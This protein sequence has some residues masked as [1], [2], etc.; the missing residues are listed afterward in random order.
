ME[1]WLGRWVGQRKKGSKA[2]GAQSSMRR[3]L[4]R[5]PLHWRVLIGV[6]ALAVSL[7]SAAV[8]SLLLYY[9][10]AFP[11]PLELRSRD[12]A[13]VIQIL[14]RDGSVLAE[15]GAAHAYL[16]IDLMPR[17]V[18][19]A[20]LATEDRRFFEHWGVDPY[21]LS[22]AFFANM[23][24]GHFAQGGSTLT[25]QLAK[26]LFLSPERSLGR[27]VEELVL[28]F[29]LEL[30]L[31]KREI[32][33]LYL[34]RVYFGGGAYGI[35]AAAQ[36][37]FDKSARQLTIG[38]AAVVAGLLKAP[39]RYAPSA[40]PRLAEAR[41]RV[42]LAKMHEARFITS[43]EYGDAKRSKIKF[44]PG[45]RDNGRSAVDYAIDYALEHLPAVIGPGQAE[46]I[47]DTTIDIR[48]Q[49]TASDAVKQ[50][51]SGGGSELGAG[52]AALVVLDTAGGIRAMVGG[53]S[54]V[55][56]QFNR[57]VK[58]RRQ[59]GSAMKP[60]VYLA[61]LENGFTPESIAYDLPVT[62]E[63][64]SPRNDNGKYQG[65]VSLRQALAQSINTV[66][67]RLIADTGPGRVADLA[68]RMGIE[69]AL[70]SDPSLALGTSEVSLLELTGAYGTFANGGRAV[71]PYMI[72]RIRSRS[73]RVLYARG[74]EPFT[75]LASPAAVGALNDMLAETVRSGTGRRAALDGRPV[76]GK[77]GTSQEFRDAWFVGYTAQLVAGVWVGNDAGEPM[78]KVTGG[79]L[80]AAIW[81]RVMTAAHVN[82]PVVALPGVG[83]AEAARFA[84][85]VSQRSVETGSAA[86]T[87]EPRAELLPWTAGALGAE[88]ASGPVRRPSHSNA[89]AREPAPGA[90]PRSKPRTLGSKVSDVPP[91]RPALGRPAYPST[92]ISSDFISRALAEIEPVPVESAMPRASSPPG[93]MTLGRGL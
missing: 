18:V 53:R 55:D 47:V 33:E 4:Q 87:S 35:E 51:L 24:A 17:A 66:A 8:A 50:E 31:S 22:R 34:N 76:A 49:A 23:R 40:N 9:T 57:A 1:L 2:R 74:P 70:R 82:E 20:V 15:R 45:L 65:P 69:S 83:D 29:W 42:V 19:S 16:P 63:G 77:T 75:Q 39:S 89:P 62:I 60:F 38:E 43:A 61:A 25:Q 27:K 59:P 41:A 48:L 80:P 67:V 46:I 37:Y 36:R 58:A 5:V 12:S 11:D 56:S 32:L 79:Q 7:G 13:P 78:N 28:A 92:S 54:Y 93:M 14:A 21:G 88:S 71:E 84:A 86:R 10:L 52:Q 3:A 91:S 81:R 68:R 72:R 6:P 85:S 64:W 44:A 90:Q 30:R 26:N 73:G